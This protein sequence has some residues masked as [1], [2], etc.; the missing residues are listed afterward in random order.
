MKRTE[1]TRA[2]AEKL[3]RAEA[4]IDAALRET[5]ELMGLLPALRL[6]TKLS[7]VLGQEAVAN[8]GETLAHIVSA[9]RTIIETH[10]AL[11]AVRSQIGCGAMAG[12]DLPKGPE[13]PRTS[14]LHAVRGGLAA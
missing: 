5:A 2:G 4:A 3:M 9:R 12:G 14:G 1:A 10:S 13:E 6:E 8:L 11:A 7:A